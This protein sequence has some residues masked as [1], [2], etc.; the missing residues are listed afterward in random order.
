M[1]HFII[2]MKTKTAYSQFISYYLRT[3]FFL[4]YKRKHYHILFTKKLTVTMMLAF[5]VIVFLIP[6]ISSICALF[7]PFFYCFL[8]FVRIKIHDFCQFR[9]RLFKSKLLCIIPF[10]TLTSFHMH[11]SNKYYFLRILF[12]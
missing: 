5:S 7:L 6:I 2:S 4:L 10:H 8:Y 1:Y 11:K 12:L 3:L 9:I